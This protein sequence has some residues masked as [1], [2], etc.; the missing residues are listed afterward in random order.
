M[1]KNLEHDTSCQLRNTN[2]DRRIG[3]QLQKN[4]VTQKLKV[5]NKIYVFIIIIVFKDYDRKV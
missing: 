4:Q 2:S 3:V 1:K 5:F